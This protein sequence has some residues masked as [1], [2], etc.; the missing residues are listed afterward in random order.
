MGPNE[1]L[2]A[3]EDGLKGGEW[4]MRKRWQEWGQALRPCRTQGLASLE[5]LGGK[6]SERGPSV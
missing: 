6:V 1:S 3:V 4:S 5:Q 2:A